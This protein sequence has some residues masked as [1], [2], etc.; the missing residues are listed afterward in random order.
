MFGFFSAGPA[1]DMRRWKQ[2]EQLQADGRHDQ[3]VPLFEELLQISPRLGLAWHGRGVSLLELRLPQEAA[4][5]FE[6]AHQC[7]GSGTEQSLLMLTACL[8]QL[9]RPEEAIALLD[10]A[11]VQPGLSGEMARQLEFAKVQ[12]C[13]QAGQSKTALATLDHYL[14]QGG[15]D[16]PMVQLFRAEA[17]ARSGQPAQACQLLQGMEEEKELRDALLSVLDET[18]V[19]GHPGLLDMAAKWVDGVDRTTLARLNHPVTV[20]VQ[21]HL[22]P[23]LDVL[24]DPS[25]V[26]LLV[27]QPSLRC[28]AVR[29]VTLGMSDRPQSG[30]GEPIWGELMLTAP[31]HEWREWVPL[32]LKLAHYPFQNNTFLW[33]GTT[34]DN[35]GLAP[36][37]D[38][39]G[40]LVFPSVSVEES[41]YFLHQPAKRTGFLSVYPLYREELDFYRSAS[42]EALL[43]R[44]EMAKISDLVLPQR[45]KAV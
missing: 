34:V 25:G 7:G 21:R 14:A 44:L 24:L 37:S 40:F 8:R 35:Q 39:A 11:L 23:L 10:G 16:A 33:R 19:V 12:A 31:S 2:M 9:A 1:L 5:S 41:F 38:Y 26:A 27:V 3:L 36:A 4:A 43:E 45:S 6:Q 30:S 29:L 20:H 13:L 15:P 42:L 32:L 17:L 22:G 18:P 28:P